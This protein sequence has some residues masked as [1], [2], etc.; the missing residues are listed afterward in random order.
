MSTYIL[1]YSLLKNGKLIKSGT[2]KVKRVSDSFPEFNAKVKLDKHLSKQYVYDN[3][4]VH[5]CKEDVVSMFGDLFG[6]A[7]PFK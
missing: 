6:N 5:S 7:N 1:E 2:M 4:V 3:M